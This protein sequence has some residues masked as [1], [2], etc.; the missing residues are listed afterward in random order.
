MRLVSSRSFWG[1]LLHSGLSAQFLPLFGALSQRFLL[2]S[3]TIVHEVRDS[4]NV[5]NI[6]QAL[7]DA[8]SHAQGM[9]RLR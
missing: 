5:F 8:D 4:H 7:P 9:V 6:E 3:A 2:G 1:V